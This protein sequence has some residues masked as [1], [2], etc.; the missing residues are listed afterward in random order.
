MDEIRDQIIS[1][2]NGSSPASAPNKISKKLSKLLSTVDLELT[3]EEANA[4]H[5][6]VQALDRADQI[7]AALRAIADH[8]TSGVGCNPGTFV[9]IA[10]AA[11]ERP[12]APGMGGE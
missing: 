5:L 8:P 3:A 7:E 1:R 6:A 11:L 2:L 9:Q 10:R 4:L 12:T